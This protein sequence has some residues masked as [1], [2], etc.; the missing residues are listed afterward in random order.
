MWDQIINQGWFYFL[1]IAAVITAIM[2]V[3]LR[4][5]VSS[6]MAMVS[7]F[8]C[9]AGLYVTLDAFFLGIIQ[10]LVYTGAVM[11]L[12]IFIIMLLDIPHEQHQKVSKRQV[13]Y[14]VL[15]VGIFMAQLVGIISK[16]DNKALPQLQ[17]AEAAKNMAANPAAAKELAG[18]NLP[19]LALIAA[20]L[21]NKYSLPFMVTGLILMSATVGV[22][23]LTR[24]KA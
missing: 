22:V 7:S 4:N 9:V 5:P 14:A 17:M 15:I 8:V 20:E 18:G 12:F 24:K 10:I 16:M 2:T 21:F 13:G 19:D 6:A 23:V 11:V 3:L 1:G